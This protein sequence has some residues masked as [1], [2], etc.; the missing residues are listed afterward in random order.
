MQILQKYIKSIYFIITIYIIVF[1]S[2]FLGGDFFGLTEFSPFNMYGIYILVFILVLVLIFFENT[3]YSLPMFTGFLFIISNS[4][5]T[6]DTLDTFG[7]PHIALILLLSS[8]LIHFIRYKSKIKIGGLFLGLLLIAIAYL[9]PLLYTDFTLKAFSVSIVGLM[10][11]IL[12]VFLFSTMKKSNIDY[13]FKL[14]IVISLLLVSQ[15]T[16]KIIRAT[17]DNSTLDF[18]EVLEWGLSHNWG[19]NFG[20]ANINDVAFY[21]TLTFPAFIYIIFKYPKNIF[22]WLLTILPVVAIA[23]SGSRGGIIGF[24]IAVI[25]II[26]LLLSRGQKYHYFGFMVIIIILLTLGILYNDVVIKTIQTMIASLQQG[27]INAISSSRIFIY[28]EGIKIFN[29]NPIFGSGWI[30]I[31]LVA[32]AS[33]WSEWRLYMFH[34]TIIHVLATMGIFGLIALL[35][36]YFQIFKILFNNFT[37]EKKLIF[38]G[39]IATQIHGL[40]DN[41]QFAVPY[42]VLI[43]IIFVV[44]EK[45]AVPTVFRKEGRKYIYDSSLEIPID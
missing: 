5:I 22:S 28:S 29:D 42:S 31:Q 44:L 39:Y 35:I 3:L 18:I 34:S 14:F 7:F 10:Y 6:F 37:L 16:T 24:S 26:L 32:D 25:L 19:P 30:S 8:L 23:I 13:L 11:F 9:I 38:I 43:P 17:L 4:S 15:L 33:G 21:I 36:H 41:V 27:T 12:Y 20:W 45:A 40:I 1:L 2:W